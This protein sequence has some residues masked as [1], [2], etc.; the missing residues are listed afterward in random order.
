MAQCLNIAKKNIN[1]QEIMQKKDFSLFSEAVFKCT[2]RGIFKKS[3]IK[4]FSQQLRI[5]KRDLLQMK[6][7]TMI[8][9]KSRW[10][11]INV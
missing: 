10:K 9:Q 11:F 3:Q 8:G 7:S 2:H 6:I 5:T 4:H 1:F